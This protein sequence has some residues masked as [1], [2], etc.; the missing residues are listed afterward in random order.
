MALIHHIKI[1]SIEQ[2]APLVKRFRL[3]KPAGFKF[4]PGHSAM[5]ALPENKN[6]AHPFTFT[7]T[8]DDPYL[9]FH[10]K[11]YDNPGNF[12]SKLHSLKLGDSLILADQFGSIRYTKPCLM[13]AAGQAIA[14]F[15]AILRQ[16]KKDGALAGNTLLHSVQTRNDLFCEEELR[17]LLGKNYIVTLT[18]ENHPDYLNGRITSQL[19]KKVLPSNKQTYV[20]GSDEFV[21]QIKTIIISF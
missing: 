20:L 18:Q 4:I 8:N 21:S 2:V 16:L 6:D 14:P 15:I 12:T 7:S 5:I 9:E 10:I 19:L 1:F 3:Q 11:R 13:I 17:Q